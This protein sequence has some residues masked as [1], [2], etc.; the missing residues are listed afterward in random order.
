MEFSRSDYRS[1]YPFGVGSLSLL[2][3]IFPTK[4]SNPGLSHFRWILY[5]QLSHKGIPRI[6]EWVAFPF[7]S[8]SSQPRDRTWV[9]HFA[10]RRF[11][12]GTTRE[13]QGNLDSGVL[14][15]EPVQGPPLVGGSPSLTPCPSGC[16]WA[17]GPVWDG[18]TN[19]VEGALPSFAAGLLS[20]LEGLGKSD[21]I[22]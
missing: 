12:V 17:H 20:G 10:D 19:W 8:G 1:G 16:F 6:L 13:A 15:V 3:R 14:S 22:T 9:S 18:W 11:T 5:Q 2:Q 4:G 7:S 21:P